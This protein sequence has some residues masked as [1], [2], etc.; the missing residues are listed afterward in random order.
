MSHT[1]N[2]IFLKID[3][4]EWANFVRTFW[5]LATLIDYTACFT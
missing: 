2:N 1:V 3:M 4:R 5:F